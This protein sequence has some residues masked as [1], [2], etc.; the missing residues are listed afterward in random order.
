MRGAGQS[1]P[2][3]Q[4]AARPASATWSRSRA[5]SGRGICGQA[6]TNVARAPKT[7][8]KPNKVKSIGTLI[9]KIKPPSYA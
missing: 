1:A 6:V 9:V 3:I 7:A 2:R 4:P 5:L 8:M